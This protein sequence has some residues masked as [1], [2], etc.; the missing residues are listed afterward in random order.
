MGTIRL[1]LFTPESD[2]RPVYVAGTFNQWQAGD[3]RYQ[4]RPIGH[5][6]YGIDLPLN[7]EW[8][9]GE[10][11]YKYT[12]GDWN[13]SELDQYGN[14]A[15]DRY[16]RPAMQTR[17][18]H[19]PR[20][21]HDGLFYRPEL[22]PR[23]EVISEKFEIPQLIR[24]RRIAALL[25]HDYYDHSSR[26]YPVL[27]LQDGQNLFDDY[28]PFGSWGVDKRLAVLSELGRGDIIVVAIDHAE[29]QRVAEFTP[30]FRT[31]LGRGD[32]KKYARFLAETLKPYIDASFRTL[33]ERQYTGIGGS[34]MGGLISMYAGMMFPRTYGKLMI[35]S[36]SLW[37]VPN[38]PFHLLNLSADFTGRIYLYG[39]GREG[40]S[41]V[42]NLERFR[43]QLQAQNQSNDIHFKLSVDPEGQHNE[44]RWGEEFPR[45]VSWLY[46]GIA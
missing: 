43:L 17:I 24:T 18:D 31:R 5:G 4:L 29:E 46:H 41:M 11:T 9:N 30:S 21:L 38:I 34:S 13:Q 16:L 44:K 40:A 45:A 7:G 32:G 20:W 37:V 23:I 22:L 25:P 39:G 3:E 27:Y 2:H 42:P 14:I 15:P 12:R 19:V 6:R 33:A 35:F 8:E 28:A 26:R 36:P 1:E 10:I